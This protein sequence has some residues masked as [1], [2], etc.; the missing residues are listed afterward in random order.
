ME[1]IIQ[2]CWIASELKQLL[3]MLPKSIFWGGK[4]HNILGKGTFSIWPFIS[5]VIFLFTY[6]LL[7]AYIFFQVLNKWLNV[8]MTKEIVTEFVFL[9]NET[10]HNENMLYSIPLGNKVGCIYLNF[11]KRQ[12]EKKTL[13]RKNIR[14]F[15]SDYALKHSGK[16]E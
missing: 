12:K 5:L 11:Y 4:I 14:S 3:S 10:V 13:L 2:R 9:G 15:Y 8:R 1:V 6:I 7:F 16:Y